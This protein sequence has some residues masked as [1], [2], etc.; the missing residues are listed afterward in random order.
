[1]TDLRILREHVINSNA[2]EG[3]RKRHGPLYTKHLHAARAVAA[4]PVRY[5]YDLP[6]I[7]RLMFGG[8]KRPRQIGRYRLCGVMM[9]GKYSR[10]HL[11]PAAEVPRLMHQYYELVEHCLDRAADHD[12]LLAMHAT[13]LCI[14]PFTDGNGRSTRLHLNAMRLVAGL[15]WLTIPFAS[16]SRY[17]GY[18]R[19]IEQEFFPTFRAHA[20]GR[21]T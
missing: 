6:A 18:I 11:P 8:L 21:D 13:A 14:H 4:D 9:V 15:D 19:R 20:L 5:V 17:Y 3:I 16:R 12:I 7:H 10:H 1:M 2:I